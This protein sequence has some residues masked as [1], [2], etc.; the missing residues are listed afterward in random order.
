MHY[1]YLKMLV[2]DNPLELKRQKVFFG[3]I[4]EIKSQRKKFFL[5]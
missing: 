1:F 4:R 3:Q 2:T 5:T